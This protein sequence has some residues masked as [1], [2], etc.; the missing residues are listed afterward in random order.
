MDVRMLGEGRP[1]VME[2]Q[3]QRAAMPGTKFFDDVQSQLQEVNST[4]VGHGL[5]VQE[6]E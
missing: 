3:N 5:D 2:I 6:A 4:P 1:F